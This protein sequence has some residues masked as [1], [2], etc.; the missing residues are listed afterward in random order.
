MA[1]ISILDCTLRDGAYITEGKFGFNAIKGIIGNLANSKIDIIETGWL[2]DIVHEKNSTYFGC[3]EDIIPYLPKEKNN[4]L[5][6]V[7]MDYGRYDINKLS[8]N[9]NDSIDAIRL[10]FPKEKHIEAIRFSE[11]IKQQGYKLYLQ[12]ANTLG[13]SKEDLYSLIEETNKIKPVGLSI[14][15]TFGVMYEDDLEEIYSILDKHLDKDIQ[16]GFHSHN[17]L[18][19][20]FALSI[21]FLKLA[22]NSK[23]D[24]ILDSSLVGMGRG[25]GN[26]CSELLVNYTNK[27]L[28]TNYNYNCIMDTIDVYMKKFI[29]NYDW[30]YSIPFCIAGQLGSHVNNIAYLQDFHKTKFKDMKMIL[31]MLPRDERKFYDYDRLEECYVKYFSKNIDD[32]NALAKLKKLFSTRELLLI[33]PGKNAEL[34]KDNIQKYIKENNPLII[35]INAAS[36]TFLYDFLFFSNKVRYD[37]VSKINPEIFAKA[38]KIITSNIK[39]EAQ[40]DEILVNFN[41]L[42][43]LGWKYFDNSTIMMLRLLEQLNIKSIAIAGFDGLDETGKNSY[44]DEV[45]QSGLTKEECISINKDVQNMFNDFKIKNNDIKIN[46]I[47]KSRYVQ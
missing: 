2:K 31:E 34:E 13:Y 23:R 28:N 24:I 35:G 41:N 21:K 32:K 19:M 3:V 14:V 10:V 45:L 5:F 26:T 9:K 29:A 46:L 16:L 42:I 18:Q 12:A 39:T 43:K 6:S 20:S 37:Y 7:M 25:A 1:K 38:K 4:S 40:K 47:T 33:C 22:K 27:Y 11:K 44:N 8:P 15:D 30:G 17:N 36:K